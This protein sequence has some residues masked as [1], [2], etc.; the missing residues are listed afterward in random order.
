VRLRQ[1]L[2][3]LVGDVEKRVNIGMAKD[4]SGVGGKNLLHQS[5][6]L[7]SLRVDNADAFFKSPFYSQLLF[8]LYRLGSNPNR[9]EK[10]EF[11]RSL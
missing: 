6:N 4:G 2:R 11:F 1:S 7:F 8:V 3:V 5:L 9:F 10:A